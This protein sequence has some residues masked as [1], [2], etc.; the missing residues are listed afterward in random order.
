MPRIGCACAAMLALLLAAG[1]LSQAASITLL[2]DPVAIDWFNETL[3]LAATTVGVEA[4]RVPEGGVAWS[5]R[6]PMVVDADAGPGGEALV[7]AGSIVYLVG[8]EGGRPLYSTPGVVAASV[9]Y[10]EDGTMAA[11]WSGETHTRVIVEIPG[12]GGVNASLPGAFL[13]LDAAPGAVAVSTS[14]A[15]YV[16]TPG[17]S[18]TAPP[19]HRLAWSPDG[20]LLAAATGDKVIVYLRDGA[21]VW[22]AAVEATGLSWSPDA[23]ILAVTGRNGTVAFYT[24]TGSLEA[25]YT[26]LEGWSVYPAGWLQGKLL[27][28]A[29]R[30]MGDSSLLVLLE[31]GGGEARL[32]FPAYLASAHPSGLIAVAEPGRLTVYTVSCSQGRGSLLAYAVIAALAAAA[33]WV[34]ARL[35]SPRAPEAGASA[36]V[37]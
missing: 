24:R 9:E 28:H 6:A 4:V 27:V 11:A 29:W 16:Y 35:K 18:W 10:E 30:P 14:E 20:R 15:L 23:S 31:P 3:L 34:R 37:H 25:T 8:P 21:R 1:C 7:A 12:G 36:E 19:A 5:F 33:L 17:H 13:A 2:G 32:H 22:S 26:A